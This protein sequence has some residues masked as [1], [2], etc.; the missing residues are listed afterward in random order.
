M[1]IIRL[2]YWLVTL[3]PV[4]KDH[5]TEI[6]IGYSHTLHLYVY[7]YISACMHMQTYIMCIII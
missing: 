7:V 4:H 6:L 3:L 2:K 5:K 1:R